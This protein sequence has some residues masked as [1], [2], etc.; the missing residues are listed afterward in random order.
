MP[1][2]RYRLVGTAVDSSLGRT[3]TGKRLDVVIPG[4]H[5]DPRLNGPYLETAATGQP[6]Y[7]KGAPLFDHNQQYRALERLL[8]PLAR[9]GHIVDML[10]CIT[11]FYGADGRLL[12][13]KL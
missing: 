11:L 2:F 12:G 4:F 3:L 10:F 8:M 9:D 1:V 7:R 6:S 5:E 13:S